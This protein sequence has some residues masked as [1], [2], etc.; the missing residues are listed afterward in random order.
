MTMT[1]TVPVAA[2]ETQSASPAAVREMVSKYQASIA[3]AFIFDLNTKDYVGNTSMALSPYL[4]TS[5]ARNFD[6]IAFYNI[7]EGIRFALP[8]MEPIVKAMMGPQPPADPMAAAIASA[9]MGGAAAPSAGGLTLPRAAGEAVRF[10]ERL[11]TFNNEETPTNPPVRVPLS[12]PQGSTTNQTAEMRPRVAVSIDYAE[13]L[14][15]NGTLSTMSDADRAV[16]VTVQR[17]GSL[18]SVGTNGHVVFLV[19]ADRSELHVNLRAASSRWEAIEVPLP[20]T[21]ERRSYIDSYIPLRVKADEDTRTTQGPSTAPLGP[22]V[23]TQALVDMTWDI[24]AEIPA[25]ERSLTGVRRAKSLRSA[26]VAT[27]AYATAGL[28]RLHIEDIFMRGM[29]EGTLTLDLVRER[30][31]DIIASEYGEVLEVREPRFGF[32]RL[33]GMQHFKD[34]AFENIIDPMRSGQ[35]EG[36][37]LGVLLTGP[38]G[39]GKSAAAEALAKEL[40]F[41]FIILNL[42]RILGQYVGQSE[43]NLERALRAI[44]S[45]APCI[46][47]V[48][49]V[50]QAM[51]RGGGGDSGVSSRI[52]KRMLEFMSDS[53][54]NRGRILNLAATN[55]PDLLDAALKRP[56]RYDDKIPFLVPSPDERWDI[57]QVMA[58]A[59]GLIEADATILVDVADRSTI[60][61]AMDGWT[62][63]EI[64]AAVVKAGKLVRRRGMSVVEAVR[65][66]TQT[67]TRSTADIEFMTA[68]AI[69][70]C[71]D[72]DLLPPSY[73]QQAQDRTAL[74][75]QVASLA[76]QARRARTME[77]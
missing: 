45:L 2:R 53:I 77:A 75:D 19:T 14:V 54:A 27:L 42:A 4:A 61:N 49:E 59:Y 21:D 24:P 46:V 37:P 60:I 34:Y 44:S 26:Q 5:L 68:L 51:S 6:V 35:R 63:A 3:H 66:A 9:G 18:S 56:G 48:D 65:H 29:N 62:G 55:R 12:G 58:R 25:N 69:Q 76:P 40:G 36:V 15:P 20:D 64:E 50:D 72:T 23:T 1:Q 52:F 7:A 74:A 16:L 22:D 39:T 47:F 31:D 11:L 43:R 32:E 30:K 57:V 38:A 8:S 28:S 17:W 33:G 41:Q 67:L 70:E 13:A 71:N 10:L 73:R